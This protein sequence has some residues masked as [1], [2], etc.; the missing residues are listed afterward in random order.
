MKIAL[1][2]NLIS[3]YQ[4]I[5]E[6]TE[7]IHAPGT[8]P[9]IVEL[10][11][12][13]RDRRMEDFEDKCNYSMKLMEIVFNQKN[14]SQDPTVQMGVKKFDIGAG[15]SLELAT[16]NHPV[17]DDIKEPMYLIYIKTPDGKIVWRDDDSYH[18]FNIFDK[19]KNEFDFVTFNTSR[20]VTKDRLM[21]SAVYHLHEMSMCSSH[22]PEGVFNNIVSGW[23]EKDGYYSNGGSKGMNIISGHWRKAYSDMFNKSVRN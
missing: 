15:F 20:N 6:L 14:G 23:N 17:F 18:S 10:I 11:S 9:K 5:D 22:N 21:T 2:S 12:E 3:G 4:K 19:E 1:A 8:D 16:W 7:I 13:L